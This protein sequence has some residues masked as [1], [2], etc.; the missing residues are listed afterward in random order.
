MS[1]KS[2]LKLFIVDDDEHMVALM[3]G[4]LEA[5][6]HSVTS[7]TA[8]AY[9]IPEIVS[10]KPDGVLIDLMMA[11]MDG[12]ELCR[13][14]RNREELK[15]TKLVMVSAKSDRHWLDRA[16][17]SGIDGYI[18]KPLAPETF[19]EQVERIVGG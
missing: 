12:L 18:T 1:T 14:L 15:H 2:P 3:A 4:L 8:G 7:E 6:G 10:R 17:A 9:A 16:H 11:E 13:Q 19:V 5:Y